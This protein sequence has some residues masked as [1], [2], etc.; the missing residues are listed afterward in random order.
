MN[1]RLLAL[2]EN[3]KLLKTLQ[4]PK[5]LP[6]R[7][8]F[9]N[10]NNYFTSFKQNKQKNKPELSSEKKSFIGLAAGGRSQKLKKV[11]RF[12]KVSKFHYR[13]DLNFSAKLNHALNALRTAMW[14]NS[15]YLNKVN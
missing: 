12:C 3:L 8:I 6:N 4:I 7:Y 9:K 1:T 10:H 11:Y 13:L 2:L 15:F 14:K 5:W